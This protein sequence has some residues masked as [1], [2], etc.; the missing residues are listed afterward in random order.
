MDVRPYLNPACRLFVKCLPVQFSTE[1]TISFLEAFGAIHVDVMSKFG[2]MKRSAFANFINTNEAKLAM[3]RL[4]Q[5]EVLGAR[6][7]VL[8]ATPKIEDQSLV[9]INTPE[10]APVHESVISDTNSKYP[11]ISPD[12][13]ANISSL[14]SSNE[15]LYTQV[16]HVIDR[17]KLP[18]PFVPEGIHSSVAMTT[19]KNVSPDGS[20]SEIELEPLR[21]SYEPIPHGPISLSGLLTK[22]TDE[23]YD[24]TRIKKRKIDIILSTAPEKTPSALYSTFDTPLPFGTIQRQ[25]T[26]PQTL[27]EHSKLPD[28][29]LGCYI[30]ENELYRDR[31]SIS[32]MKRNSLYGGY[33]IGSPSSRIYIKNLAK[34]ASEK[35]L[36]YIYGRYVDFSNEQDCMSYVI[37][38]LQ[39]GRMRG[40]A[41]VGLS[42]PIV[43]RRA[44]EDTNGYLLHGRPMVVQFARSAL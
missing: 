4:H 24:Y 26:P 27:R 30:S 6:L 13:L 7:I 20:D 19:Q 33:S 18:I 10:S 40:Q 32:E 21:A 41:F 28:T 5:L 9:S 25:D 44:I 35:D 16:L 2:K 43:A 34:K 42:S 29:Y 36:Q 31:L 38:I 23:L 8:W 39:S 11:K 12:A 3:N 14:I 1:D 37:T 15:E 22:R 17:M